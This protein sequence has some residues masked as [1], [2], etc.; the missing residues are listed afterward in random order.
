MK[1]VQH[2]VGS[3][4]ASKAGGVGST[5]QQLESSVSQMGKQRLRKTE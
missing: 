5:T 1:R 4:D 2:S 3:C